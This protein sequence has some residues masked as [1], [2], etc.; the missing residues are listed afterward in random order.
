M[1]QW[2]GPR[3]VRPSHEFA[4]PAHVTVVIP[5]HNYARFLPSAVTS[6][7]TQRGVDVDVIVVDDASSDESLDVAARMSRRDPRVTVLFNSHNLGPV[8][9]FNRGL[10]AATGEFLVR[11]DADDLLTPGALARAVA[12]MQAHPEVGL[13]YGHPIHFSG[14]DLPRARTLPSK[15]LVWSG[16]DW[17]RARCEAGNN[18][19]TSPEVLMRSD[20]VEQVGGQRDLAHT[21]DMEMWLR[22]AAV[23]DIAYVAGVDQAWHR[24]HDQSLSMANR[25]P[26]GERTGRRDAFETLFSGSEMDPLLASQ[27]L[28]TA[29][30][31]LAREALVD[32][33]HVYDRGRADAEQLAGG[34]LAFALE[35]DPSIKEGSLASALARRRRLGPTRVRRRPWHV[36]VA[37]YRSL[38]MRSAFR[39]WHRTGVYERI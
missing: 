16:V 24:I 34:L 38:R 22:I 17:L 23:S 35:C 28:L 11:L 9:T 10:N 36:A 2:R 15:W 27:L 31:A 13:V 19:I 21:H 25:D 1:R 5:C 33:C 39:R 32:A 18:V 4:Q 8:A 37:A 14:D 29:R 7:L 6:A 30:R 12:V 20:V 3:A 26:V